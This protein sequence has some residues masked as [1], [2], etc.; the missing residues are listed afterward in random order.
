MF[1]DRLLTRETQ[2]MR[3]RVVQENEST[4][5]RLDSDA[6]ADYVLTKLHICHDRVETH[7]RYIFKIR[8]EQQS[9]I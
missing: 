5:R 3:N 4:L 1:N 7:A 6:N 2:I 8:T 9:Q